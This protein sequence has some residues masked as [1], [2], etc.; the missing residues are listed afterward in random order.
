MGLLRKRQ[1][2]E[3]CNHVTLKLL[4]ILVSLLSFGVYLLQ[5]NK[6]TPSTVFT[7][8]MIF[9]ILKGPLNELPW[10]ILF[11]IDFFISIRRIEEFIEQDDVDEA[12]IEKLETD[13]FNYA[14]EIQNAS[15]TWKL[16]QEE[17]EERKEE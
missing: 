9:S 8:I 2:F 15:F 7:V 5:G 14:L 17:K 4:P 1:K 12:K 3:V 13:S 6:L 16:H 10:Q 11:F